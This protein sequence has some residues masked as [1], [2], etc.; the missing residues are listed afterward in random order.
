MFWI[1][2]QKLEIIT[3]VDFPHLPFYCTPDMGPRPTYPNGERVIYLIN[4]CLYIVHH[5]NQFQSCTPCSKDNRI[6]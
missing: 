4:H 5:I 1:F 3:Y 6:I 2:S